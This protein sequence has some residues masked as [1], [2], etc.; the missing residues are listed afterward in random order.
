MAPPSI[1]VQLDYDD[2]SRVGADF[3]AS[4]VAARPDAAVLV[5]TGETP[6][7]LYAELAC[8][9]QAG[10]FDGSRLRVFQLD[11]YAGLPDHDSRSLYAWTLRAFVDPLRI[12]HQRVVRLPANGDIAGGC[13]AYDRSVHDAGG[14][15]LAILGIGVNG[16]I[17]FN[18]PPSDRSTTTRV[19]ELAPKTI[20]ANARYW[21]RGDPVARLGVTAGMLTVLNARRTLL[22][23][24]G[25]RKRG[26]IRRAMSGP[27]SPDVPAS[28]LREADDVTVLLDRLAWD[29]GTVDT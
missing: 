11:E 2:L 15:D 12:P 16:H 9:Q 7:G 5:A 1:R 3:V 13:A 8:R 20:R 29:G 10:T 19:V 26:I 4:F 25:R 27:I 24:S 18:E 23:A 21:A 28:L 17:G 22:L 14:I 6:M